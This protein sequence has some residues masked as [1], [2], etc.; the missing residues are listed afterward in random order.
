MSTHSSSLVPHH[1]AFVMDG[2]GRWA[3]KQGWQR[4]VGHKA[5]IETV[6][7]ILKESMERRIKFV[8]FYA[9]SSENWRRPEAEVTGLFAL[10]QQYFKSELKELMA[11]NIKVQF[12][13]DRAPGSKLSPKIIQLM[14]EVEEK[15]ADN[16][17][18][19][20]T[21]AINYGAR[22]E[23]TRAAAELAQ[24]ELEADTPT[25]YHSENLGQF[26]DTVNLPDVDFMVRTGGEQRL[27]NFMLWQLA[28]AELYFTPAFWPD[29]D[30]AHY[31]VALND[32][33]NRQRRFGG[34]IDTPSEGTSHN[35]VDV[36]EL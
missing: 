11:Q 21:F 19:T 13:G 15:T 7:T 33:A 18:I 1:I 17:A 9:F 16:A 36:E 22:N 29:F 10:M 30:A 27:S 34:L 35:V 8:T 14:N 3:Q 5:G 25:P 4:L 26:L 31:Q 24:H 12:I 23:L 20:A 2:N 32:F 6:K 28:Y